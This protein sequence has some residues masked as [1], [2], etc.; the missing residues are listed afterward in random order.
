MRTVTC[1]FFAVVTLMLGNI[2]AGVGQPSDA[3][4]AVAALG[5]VI[6]AVAFALR[7]WPGMPTADVADRIGS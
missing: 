1:L 2:R 7:D 4:P 5:F 3:L 6:A